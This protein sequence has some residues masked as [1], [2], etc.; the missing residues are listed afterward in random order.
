[1]T[2]CAWRWLLESHYVGS[3]ISSMTTS[4]S[5]RR[6]LMSKRRAMMTPLPR[7]A[8]PTPTT[9]R[10]ATTMLMSRR[11]ATTIPRPRFTALTQSL[12]MSLNPR[13]PL[14]TPISRQR[15][16]LRHDLP[17]MRRRATTTPPP[18]FATRNPTLK[19]RRRTLRQ[20]TLTGITCARISSGTT[21][22]PEMS[23]PSHP[24]TSVTCTGISSST[25][26]STISTN[27]LPNG[28]TSIPGTPTSTN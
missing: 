11:R 7:S 16:I 26:R 15:C 18:H 9:T 17:S 23:R 27:G 25:R 12:T 10:R 8:T 22:R 13:M 19:L 6:F 3:R 24:T 20:A 4:R 14:N 28:C 21:T 2:S 5:R 1:M